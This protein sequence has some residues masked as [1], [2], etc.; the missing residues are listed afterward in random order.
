V[1]QRLLISVLERSHCQYSCLGMSSMNRLILAV[2]GKGVG[3]GRF[4]L[5]PFFYGH[6]CTDLQNVFM[7]LF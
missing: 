2:A 6:C 4:G 5:R 3:V 7:V 1:T